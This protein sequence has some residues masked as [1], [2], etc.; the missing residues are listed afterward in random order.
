MSVR[1]RAAQADRDRAREQAEQYR[2]VAQAA[3]QRA[4]A[5]EGIRAL[6]LVLA[7]YE[8]ARGGK[9]VDLDQKG[10]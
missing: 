6:E 10:N 5:A 2:L 9:P 3:E 4:A 7:I 1:G 8:S